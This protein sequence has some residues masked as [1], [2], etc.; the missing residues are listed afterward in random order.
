VLVDESSVPRQQDFS[1]TIVKLQQAG[2]TIV[3][4]SVAPVDAVT[5]SKQAQSMGYHPTWF[6]LGSEW[7]YNLVL[8]SAG[9]AM[10]G[11]ISLSPWVSIDSAAAARWRQIYAE[12]N[13]GAQADDLGLNI[14]A[15]AQLVLA[16]M[17]AAGPNMSVASVIAKMNDVNLPALT[18]GASALPP[19]W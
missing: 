16:V 5:I 14:F 2:C 18:D 1:S 8:D 11:A 13:N 4:L 12:Y 9:M 3:M 17:K 15:L 7:N 19:G 6:G 10:D